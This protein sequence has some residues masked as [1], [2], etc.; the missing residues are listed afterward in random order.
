VADFDTPLRSPGRPSFDQVD[1]PA[2]D[3]FLQ[4]CRHIS[5]SKTLK[6][7]L[8]RQLSEQ[9]HAVIKSGG[10]EPHSRMPSEEALADL[11]GVSRPVVRNALRSLAARGLIVKVHRKG[12]FVGA[13]PLE[14]DF[15]T[16]NISAY[17]M[18]ER[19]H[20]VTS[21]TFQFLRARADDQEREALQLDENGTV[22]RIERVFWMN[23]AP[24]SYALTSL[25]GEKAPGFETLDIEDRSVLGL[26]RDKY[27][28]RIS[29]AERWFKAAVPPSDVAVKLQVSADVPMIW[30][31][32]IGYEA[33][34]TPLEYYRAFYNSDIAPIH[35]SIVD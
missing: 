34:N 6:L 18:A 24:I 16:T 21:Q 5:V 33:D 22:V 3:R 20:R 9:L 27:E 31:E 12:V 30:I 13:P 29:R 15:I 14:A 25:H 35:L 32:S 19:G 8:W 17:D 26:L 11:F 1:K 23:G 28:R 10:L 7:P 4:A 2:A